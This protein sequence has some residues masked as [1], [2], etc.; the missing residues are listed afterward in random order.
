MPSIPVLGYRPSAM[1]NRDVNFGSE[2]FALRR[3][4]GMT[5]ADVASRAGLGR[6]YYSQLENSKKG[7]PSPRLLQQIADALELDGE[8]ARRL[9]AVAVADRCATACESTTA[10]TPIAMLVKSLVQAAS[11]IT[12]EKV[13]RIEAILQEG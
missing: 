4:K 8:Q 13:A 10:S 11:H 7:P 1:C 12:T 9:L 6:G 2:L 3:L 5:Q